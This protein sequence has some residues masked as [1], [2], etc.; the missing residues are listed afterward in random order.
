[1]KWGEND[2]KNVCVYFSCIFV[3]KATV[4]TLCGRVYN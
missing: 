4:V 1:M 2:L 3:D